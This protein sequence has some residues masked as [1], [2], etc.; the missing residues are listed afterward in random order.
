MNT[1][2]EDLK[3]QI[4]DMLEGKTNS[5]ETFEDLGKLLVEWFAENTPHGILHQHIEIDIRMNKDSSQ[6]CPQVDIS[7]WPYGKPNE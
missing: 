3:N 4:A 7:V 6:E 2:K 5:R 1:L